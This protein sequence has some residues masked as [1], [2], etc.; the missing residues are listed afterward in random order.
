MVL[1]GHVKDILGIDF[2]PNGFVLRSSAI[3]ALPYQPHHSHQIATGSNDDTVRIWDMRSLK[4]IK[5]IPAHKSAVSDVKFFRAPAGGATYPTQTIPRG[6]AGL[7]VFGEDVRDPIE[8]DGEK[9]DVPLAG[10]FLVSGGYDG[11]VKIWSADDWQLVKSMT[12]DAAGKVMSIDV[13]S[14]ELR[15]DSERASGANATGFADARFL[16]SAEY[17][18]TFKLWSNPSTDLS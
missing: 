2:S 11:M 1:D 4:S 14:G 3:P 15:L 17:S 6:L 10:S 16:A 5:T 18:R 12:S 8:R 9:A 7:P 13:S